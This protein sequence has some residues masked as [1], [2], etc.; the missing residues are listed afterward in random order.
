MRRIATIAIL[1][2]AFIVMTPAA[3]ALTPEECESL[4]AEGVQ[5]RADLQKLIDRVSEDPSVGNTS[6]PDTASYVAELIATAGINEFGFA[7]ASADAPLDIC[8]PEGTTQVTLASDPVVVW[9]GP[10][11][12]ANQPVTIEIPAGIECGTH[13]LRATGDGVD[14]S[15]SFVIGGKCTEVKGST[16]SS[17]LPRTGADIGRLVGLGVALIAV[18][19][20]ISRRRRTSRTDEVVV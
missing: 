11:A 19:F 12:S 16:T 20:S 5:A 13:T 9:T 15:V 17:F 4:V 6:D 2:T 8:L 14:Q 10:P 1:C 3:H 18:G 7:S